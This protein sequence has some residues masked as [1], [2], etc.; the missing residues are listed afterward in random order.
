MDFITGRI[1]KKATEVLMCAYMAVVACF[2]LYF[3]TQLDKVP[4]KPSCQ[5]VEISPDFSTE[6]REW[7][8][9]NRG[10]HRL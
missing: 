9:K 2:S 10:R 4:N 1:M 5:L 8:R 7:C 3:A 6:H